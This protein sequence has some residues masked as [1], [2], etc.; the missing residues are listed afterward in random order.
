MPRFETKLSEIDTELHPNEAG[1][2]APKVTF[3]G[4]GDAE[5]GFIPGRLS[6]SEE[7]RQRRLNF[8]SS[9]S[10]SSLT[11][12][13]GN[14]SDPE[15]ES[16]KG[17]IE[18]YIG[19][20]RVPTGIIGPV[21]VEGNEVKGNVYVP[22]ATTEGALISSYNRG[23]KATYLS[24]GVVSVCVAEAIQRAPSFRFESLQEAGKFVA[25]VSE[26]TEAFQMVASQ[27]SRFALLQNQKI[28]LEGNVVTLIFS[29]T[30]GEAAGQNM[31]TICTQAVCQFILTH[32]PVTP[33]HW[34]IEGNFSGDKKATV[35]ALHEVRGKKVVAEAVISKKILSS[36]LKTTAAEMQRYWQTSVLGTVQSGGIGLQGHFANGLAAMFL[37]TGQDVACVAEAANGVTRM[38]VV[39]K[40]GL[41]I[42]V[43]LPNLVVGTI[44]GGTS[45][46]TQ[47]EC[48]QLMN[49]EGPGSAR[50]LAEIM[51]AVILG[52]ELS[53]AAAV[54]SHD[55]V[56][57]HKHLGRK[58]T[59]T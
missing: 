50:K 45:L 47:R 38:E 4:A 59:K 49:C 48:L 51:G 53:I 44:G 10:K 17:N 12:L 18:Q 26:L 1:M 52:G 42:S 14:A 11:A 54:A 56:R 9:L 29:Y 13:S 43:T 28:H 55:F 36:V 5:G 40:D 6:W 33:R 24:G 35:S 32:S 20:T 27:T 7:S 21:W 37:A 58:N 3:E 15:A 39:E 23:A 46:P 31:I 57:A 2:D 25:W 41:Y 16:L 19:M 22:M 34:F 30:T 8:L